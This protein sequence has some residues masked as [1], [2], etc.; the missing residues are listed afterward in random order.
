MSLYVQ[1]PCCVPET[2]S[3]QSSIAPG[4][5]SLSTLFYHNDPGALGGVYV[6]V[7]V[8]VCDTDIPKTSEVSFSLHLDQL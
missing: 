3:L 2:L 7:C 4:F 1:L 6:R 8:R 5:Y